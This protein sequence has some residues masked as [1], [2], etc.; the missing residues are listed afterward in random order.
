LGIPVRLKIPKINVDASIIDVGLTP[1]GAMDVP[2]GPYE[3]AW[4]NL[5]PRPGQQGSAVIDGHYG[6]WKNGAVSVFQNLQKL[7]KGDKVSVWDDKGNSFS[8]VVTKSKMYAPTDNAS[9]VFTSTDGK[10]HLNLITC[11]WDKASQ[12]YSKRLVIFT[13]K[14]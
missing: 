6:K 11:V 9:E 13:D 8:F 7:R 4:Y 3:V 2:K 1:D 12:S 14:G 5:G 10:S